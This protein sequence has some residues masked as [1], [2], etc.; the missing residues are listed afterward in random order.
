M[1]RHL[2]CLVLK[3][4]LAEL[5]AWPSRVPLE[6][7]MNMPPV[8]ALSSWMETL[9]LPSV[10]QREEWFLLLF[11][12]SGKEVRCCLCLTENTH[13]SK[14]GD[15]TQDDNTRRTSVVKESQ[16]LKITMTK[17]MQPK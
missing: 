15:I 11:P 1:Y 16:T 6:Q 5:K 3:A 7:S 9:L 14:Q 12:E 8:S 10:L 13:C 2:V 17:I 4:G